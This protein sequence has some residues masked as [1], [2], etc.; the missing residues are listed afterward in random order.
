M[1]VFLGRYDFDGDATELASAYDRMMDDVP[2]G[3]VPFH[4][5]VTRTDG[6]TVFD[7]C[8][9]QEVFEEFSTSA[10][11]LEMVRAAGRPAPRVARVG[12]VHAARTGD[13]LIT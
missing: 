11:F 7:C 13:T 9:S 10:E 4:L 2:G 3:E 1:S 8:P 12:E 5:C 6:L